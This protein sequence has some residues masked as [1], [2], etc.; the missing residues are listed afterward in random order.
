[1]VDAEPRQL[2]LPRA[3][4]LYE[5][6]AAEEHVGGPRHLDTVDHQRPPVTFTGREKHQ[7]SFVE[8]IRGLRRRRRRAVRC[9]ET[10]H[11]PSPAAKD[12]RL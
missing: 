5:F 8:A 11:S 2:F 9:G 3:R 10:S 12:Y 6:A 7:G 1:M 4:W